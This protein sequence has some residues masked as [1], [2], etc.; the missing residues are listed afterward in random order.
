MFM[1]IVL[2]FIVV[3]VFECS[4]VFKTWSTGAQCCGFL[5]SGVYS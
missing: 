4:D 1:N 3:L 5:P 2:C